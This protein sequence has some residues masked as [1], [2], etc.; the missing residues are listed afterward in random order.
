MPLSIYFTAL[1]SRLVIVVGL[2]GSLIQLFCLRFHKKTFSTQTTEATHRVCLASS[3]SL[4]QSD[5]INNTPLNVFRTQ[6]TGAK[7]T[8]KSYTLNP[9]QFTNDACTEDIIIEV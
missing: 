1:L 5:A 7:V 3:Y 4:A 8:Y 9:P 2:L 6:K